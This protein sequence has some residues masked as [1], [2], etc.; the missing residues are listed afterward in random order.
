[1]EYH[2]NKYIQFSAGFSARL[3]RGLPW[4]YDYFIK[5]NEGTTESRSRTLEAAA[6]PHK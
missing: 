4:I 5:K 2:T 6:T 1:M 3:K